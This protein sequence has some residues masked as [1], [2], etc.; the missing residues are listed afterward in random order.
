V[1]FIGHE[2]MRSDLDMP[3]INTQEKEVSE[4]QQ[5]LRP[6]YFTTI[7]RNDHRDVNLNMNR[8]VIDETTKRCQTQHEFDM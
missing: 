1:D 2:K 5:K 7:S 8:H 3:L 6:Q 4:P